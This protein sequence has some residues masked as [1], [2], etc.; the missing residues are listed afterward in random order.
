M[1]QLCHTCCQKQPFIGHQ[2][3]LY[4]SGR[5]EENF[6]IGL[7]TSKYLIRFDVHN[8]QIGLNLDKIKVFQPFL[9]CC[10]IWYPLWDCNV[11]VGVTSLF[12]EHFSLAGMGRTGFEPW[13]LKLHRTELGLWVILTLC[14]WLVCQ[15]NLATNTLHQPGS[16][17]IQ[18]C[19]VI[20]ISK[21][22]LGLWMLIDLDSSSYW[23]H[24]LI[25]WWDK[26]QLVT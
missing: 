17:E 10:F 4:H 5:C 26:L 12:S 21:S 11:T 3:G 20:K 1:P 9:L 23:N 15:L 8:E 24:L 18:K 13:Q 6:C 19:R 7:V 22:G 14:E 25:V 16:N 2:C